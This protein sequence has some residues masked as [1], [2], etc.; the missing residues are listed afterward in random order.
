MCARRRVSGNGRWR[1]VAPAAPLQLDAGQQ[2]TIDRA[3]IQAATALINPETATAWR[4]GRLTFRGEPLRHVIEDVNRY[5]AKPVG[6][7][8]PALGELRFTGTI[9]NDN[10]A[11]WIESLET[12][13]GM[14]A[15]EEKQRIVLRKKPLPPGAAASRGQ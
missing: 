2:T 15:I 11:G 6:L 7:D 14:E 1:A 4:S 3:G 9:L 10:V 12:V 5:A 8:Q 13:F